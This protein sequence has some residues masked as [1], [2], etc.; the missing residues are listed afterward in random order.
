GFQIAIDDV[1]TGYNS[2]L[3]IAE[4]RPD[5]VKIDHGLVRNIDT[6]GTHRALLEAIVQYTRHIGTA[7]LAE[8][9]ETREELATIIQMG[10][11]YGQGYLMG[12]PADDFRGVPRA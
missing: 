11:P 9:I 8:G 7:A 5:F 10:I 3:A 12:R 2:L 4:L 6:N 1:G